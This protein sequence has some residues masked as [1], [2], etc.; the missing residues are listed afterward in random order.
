MPRPGGTAGFTNVAGHIATSR[1]VLERGKVLEDKCMKLKVLGCPKGDYVVLFLPFLTPPPE[2]LIIQ[3]NSDGNQA[4]RA[5]Y[6]FTTKSAAALTQS[7]MAA[8]VIHTENRPQPTALPHF[9][10]LTAS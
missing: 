3:A 10:G 5:S 6:R 9:L 7:F 1:T 4:F 2:C 8:Q